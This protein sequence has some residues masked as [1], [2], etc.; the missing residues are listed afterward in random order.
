MKKM[1]RHTF[2]Q[3]DTE[4]D[5][6]RRRVVLMGE[7]VCLQV[8]KAVEGVTNGDALL[9]EQVIETE[10]LINREE[11]ELDEF[12]ILLIAR[13]APA[14]GDLRLLMTIM[15]M[16][17]DLERVGDEAKKIAKAGRRIIES[18]SM[19]VPKI[20]LR[21]V[22]TRA[23]AMLSKALDAFVREDTSAAAEIALEDK[24]VDAS[25]KGITRQLAT[26]MM[27]D[28][29]LI[30]RSLDMLFIA[31]SIERV[32]DHATNVSEYV[33]Y[34]VKGRDVRHNKNIDLVERESGTD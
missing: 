29:R 34:M 21:Y 27:E 32:G 26:F 6:L 2:T 8:Q 33:V 17:T 14:A 24:E 11:V 30:T 13:H 9:L 15:R 28:P 12:C 23:V 31:K 25:F 16:I 1:T 4:L 20:E 18:D 7:Q 5:E 10:Q 3:F 19:L 22:A